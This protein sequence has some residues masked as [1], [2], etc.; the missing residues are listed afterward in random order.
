MPTSPSK[1]IAARMTTSRSVR[2]CCKINLGL[3]IL[4][5]RP[6]GYHEIASILYPVPWCDEL[7]FSPLDVRDSDT[8]KHR[9]TCSDPLLPT[10]GSNLCVKARL[11][12]EAAFGEVQ[13]LHIH[14]EKRVPYGAGLGSGSSDAAAVLRYLAVAAGMDPR[15]HEVMRVAAGIGSD[16]PFFLLDGPAIASGRG[17]ELQPIEAAL[18][19][20]LVVAVPDVQ[21]SSADAYAGVAASRSYSVAAPDLAE[22]LS[23]GD[24]A[25]W[26]GVLRN[27]FEP[28]V[29]ATFPQIAR[30]KATMEGAA[31]GAGA[32]YVSLSGSGSAVYGIYETADG[33]KRAAE[34][35]QTLGCTVWRGEG[36]GASR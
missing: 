36:M 8:A 25:Y 16:V 26:S 34:R 17:E 12:F 15:S 27:D 35:A 6:D 29:F 32:S 3:Y 20:T 4:G 22:V 9:F 21:I 1:L 30:L 18:N 14:L 10:D 5:R 11:A 19:G 2:A 23:S 31:A 28:F 7:T 13:P 33:A 24:L